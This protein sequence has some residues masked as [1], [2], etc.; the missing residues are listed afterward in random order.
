[1]GTITDM[2][3]GDI[4]GSK[5]DAGEWWTRLGADI[6]GV[7]AVVA[8]AAITV[9]SF[10]IAS[11]LGLAV[12][13]AGAG[14]L[15]A[16]GIDGADGNAD[17]NWGNIVTGVA[18]G[19]AMGGTLGAGA[20][21]M[22]AGSIL[23]VGSGS[24]GIGGTVIGGGTV[25]NTIAWAAGITTEKLIKGLATDQLAESTQ[26]IIDGNKAT[27]DA[28]EKLHG[29]AGTIKYSET[30][31]NP[32]GTKKAYIEGG[33]G[34]KLL[35]QQQQLDAEVNKD[36]ADYQYDKNLGYLDEKGVL[37]K[38]AQ[39]RRFDTGLNADGTESVTLNDADQ[40]YAILAGIGNDSLTLKEKLDLIDSAVQAGL[41][42]ESLKAAQ[43]ARQYAVDYNDLYSETGS[44]AI[45]AAQLANQ[46]QT[47]KQDVAG[48]FIQRDKNVA[49]GRNIAG[50]FGVSGGSINAQES[51]MKTEADIQIERAIRANGW[52]ID[53]IKDGQGGFDAAANL[54]ISGTN[55]NQQSFDAQTQRN[56]DLLKGGFQSLESGVGDLVG[57]N[58]DWYTNF[59]IQDR[60][61]RTNAEIAKSNSDAG[62]NLQ[63]VKFGV[64][65]L[66]WVAAGYQLQNQ[67][68][69]NNYEQLKLNE[70]TSWQNQVMGYLT[71]GIKGATAGLQ[72]SKWWGS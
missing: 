36:N 40:L 51:S 70:T 17:I 71:D 26:A 25:A 4:M 52:T 10:G 6:A 11:N 68:N 7:G 53:A 16:S 64:D 2:F 28:L 61:Y 48:A 72:L 8:G 46:I 67:K 32:N 37:A 33:S 35:Y 38:G 42:T 15:I 18:I 21:A 44:V 23:T 63:D 58:N 45:Q 43:Q 29:E 31:K 14:E 12:A 69:Q 62:F 41:G 20:S 66:K 19:G 5:L 30:E 56:K 27:V 22:G 1:M 50:A 49:Q 57:G 13:G 60:E 55:L 3:D 39:D 65:D 24:L 9:G 34:E 59:D 47:S 54:A